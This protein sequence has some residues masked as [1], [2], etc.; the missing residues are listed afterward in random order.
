MSYMQENPYQ[1][2]EYARPAILAAENERATF[3]QRTYIHLAGAIALF[4]AFEAAIFLL[5]PAA[6]LESLMGM[7]LGGRWSWLVVMLGFMAV[8]WLAQTWANS[9]ASRGMQYIGLLLYVVAQGVLFI[10]LLYIAN[11]FAPGAI[12]ASGLLTL[13]MF[14]GLTALVFV[15]GSD[16]TSWGKY[17]W[18]AGLAVL[19]VALG[20]TLFG[21]TL[22]VWFAG[23]MVGLASA[24][25]L[26]DTSNVLHRYRT[27]QY[28]A[29]SLALFASVALLFWYILQ[30]VMSLNR[31]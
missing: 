28:V 18:C 31:R 30:L 27:E 19:G 16:L 14:G 12:V 26:Y 1:S 7:M 21:F 29:A 25:I 3:I 24:Y 22:G 2:P 5:V 4:V 15:T 13:V 23:A 8:S 10:P 11:R 20:A 9:D 6:A 17:L